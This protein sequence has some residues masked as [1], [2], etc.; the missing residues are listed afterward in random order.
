MLE[1]PWTVTVPCRPSPGARTG[2]HPVV[3]APDWSIETG[4]DEDLER[5]A[6]ALGSGVSCLPLLQRT[7]AALRLWWE[8][9]QRSGG[10]AITSDDRGVTWRS[11]DGGLRCCPARGF[12][13]PREAGAHAR[14]T[15]HVALFAGADPRE[16]AG[17]VG[18]A[19]AQAPP[20]PPD[21]TL[22]PPAPEHVTREAWEVGL[23]PTWVRQ[24]HAE[25]AAQSLVG[26]DLRVLLGIAQTSAD[27][28]W[29]ARTSAAAGDNRSEHEPPAPTL[30]RWLAWT[31]TEQD[32][33]LP[34]ARSQ[35][36][37]SG[38]RHTDIEVLAAA[39]Y[40][41]TTAHDVAQD[42]G[43]SVP[44]AG[45]I[46]ARWIRAGYR[47]TPEQLRWTRESGATFPPHPPSVS[48]VERVLAGLA[49]RAQGRRR[50]PE[51]SRP[52]TTDLAV[53]LTRFGTV[54]DTVSAL[55]DA[56]AHPDAG[57]RGGDASPHVG[58]SSRT[59]RRA[60]RERTSRKVD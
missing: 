34:D 31:W 42:W 59:T 1:L 8:R 10:L 27:P 35:W 46:L 3:I 55:R 4:H 38:T 54:P 6:V 16:L 11:S 39:G 52:S 22:G 12:S 47:P 45:Q 24:V 60:A 44:G 50:G 13:D 20:T 48:A 29:V 30:A 58:V 14:A 53:A 57:T 41:P 33:L 43:L 23:H 32:Q 18:A 28:G 26:L 36:V 19:A 40:P 25:W 15:R 37:R 51:R 7:S 5:I 2:R 17:L 9:Q 21:R 49:S 56:A